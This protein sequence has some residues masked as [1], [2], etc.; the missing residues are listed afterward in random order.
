MQLLAWYDQ[1]KRSLPWRVDQASLRDPWRTWVSE[2]ML[3][4]TLIPVVIPAYQRFMNRFPDVFALAGASEDDVRPFVKGLGYYRRFGM[5]HRA[6]RQ[7]ASTAVDGTPQWPSTQDE[8]KSLPGIGEYTSAAICS[9]ALGIPVPVIDGNVERVLCRLADIRRPPNLPELKPTYRKMAQ[10]LMGDRA[11]RARPGDFNQAMM[12]LGQR[13]CTPTSPSCGDCPLAPGCLARKSAS[14]HLAPAPKLRP[15]YEDVRLRMLVALRRNRKGQV[16]VALFHRE[17]DARFLKG[18]RG[19]WY[20]NGAGAGT[21]VGTFKH[22][23]TRHKITAD[24]HLIEVPTAEHPDK[25]CPLTTLTE[26]IPDW[27]PAGDIEDKLI[28][29]LDLKAW[30]LVTRRHPPYNHRQP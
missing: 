9:I 16:E 11:A 1:N 3:Q 15:Q 6:A 23:I 20:T 30:R 18:S 29:N 26:K 14:Q 21:L 2:V 13:I 8:W 27:T 12:E 22:S 25:P 28:S 10:E 17:Q 19:F 24:V 4:Q 5:L 7:V